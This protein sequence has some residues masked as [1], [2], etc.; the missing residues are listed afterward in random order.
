MADEFVVIV[1]T[2]VVEAVVHAGSLARLHK[3][4][5]NAWNRKTEKPKLEDSLIRIHTM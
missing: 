1:T 4:F 3:H 5:R 2:A